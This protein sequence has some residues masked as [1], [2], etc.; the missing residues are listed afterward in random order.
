MAVDKTRGQSVR[1]SAETYQLLKQ[2]QKL[3]A[4]RGID[5]LPEPYKSLLGPISQDLLMNMALADLERCL[6]AYSGVDRLPTP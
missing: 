1:L 2:L 4:R 6:L 3:I 5:Q